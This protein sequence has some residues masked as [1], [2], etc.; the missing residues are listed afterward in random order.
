MTIKQKIKAIINILRDKPVRGITLGVRVKRCDECE[1][2]LKCDEC[3]YKELF[4]S[5]GKTE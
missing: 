3:A 2:N 5:L 1:Y 4:T